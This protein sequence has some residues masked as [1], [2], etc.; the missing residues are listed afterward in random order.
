[1]TLESLMQGMTDK[2]NSMNNQVITLT[3]ANQDVLLGKK[4]AT[5]LSCNPKD[6]L[7]TKQI[8]GRNGHMYKTYNPAYP[9]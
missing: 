6:G 8:L 7:P 9:N 3:E 2:I 1:M 5:C 4:G